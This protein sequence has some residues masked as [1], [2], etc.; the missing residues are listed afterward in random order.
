MF[1]MIAMPTV[2][3]VALGGAIGASARYFVGVQA[4][5]LMGPGFPWGT[6]SVNIVGSFL[7]GVLIELLALKINLPQDVRHFLTTGVLGGFTTFS[8]FS[9][10][11]AVLYERKAH[12]LAW[13]YMGAS[14]AGS[15]LALF[16]GLWLMRAVLQ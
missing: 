1:Y 7:M 12:L 2:I 15:I 5:R 13:S 6:L 16:A 10:D 4:L 11:F 8:A 14:V 3:W 9:L